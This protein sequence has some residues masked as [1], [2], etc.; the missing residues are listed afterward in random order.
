M[1]DPALRVEMPGP[2][3]I[4]ASLASSLR[5]CAPR[6]R[7]LLNRLAGAG[8]T[9]FTAWSAA[10]LL[11]VSEDEATPV[12]L[13]MSQRHLVTHLYEAGG[14]D[15]Y[16]LHDHVRETLLLNGPHRLGVP[17][18]ELPDWFTGGTRT[19][20]GTAPA[21][22]RPARDR[23]RPPCR[24]ASVEFRRRPVPPR[25]PLGAFVEAGTVRPS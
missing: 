17:E 19:R 15:R 8:L 1:E 18:E 21:R 20:G 12:L 6:E 3:A 25:P 22:V 23:G 9:T 16:Q 2:K 14:F 7:L 11:R 10:A 24:A 5:R 13:E 4:A